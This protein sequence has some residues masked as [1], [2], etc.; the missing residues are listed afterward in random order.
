MGAQALDGLSY[1]GVDLVGEAGHEGEC[2]HIAV[3][4]AAGAGARDAADK[5]GVL[6]ILDLP[7]RRFGVNAALTVSGLAGWAAGDVLTFWLLVRRGVAWC[8]S[9]AGIAVVLA[10]GH[11]SWLRSSASS[12][13]LHSIRGGLRSRPSQR[14]RWRCP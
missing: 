3:A 1:D 14:E 12:R 8:S 2:L 7:P 11:R 10:R 4:D 5:R 9:W 13:A 6:V